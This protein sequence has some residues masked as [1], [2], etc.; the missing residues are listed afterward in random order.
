MLSSKGIKFQKAQRASIGCF[1][2]FP[3]SEG[4]ISL[5]NKNNIQI[6]PN[7]LSN[8]FDR[9]LANKAFRS[10]IDLLMK[11]C[12]SNSG[13]NLIIYVIELNIRSETFS[14]FHLIGTNRMS[15]DKN[16]G[17]V[18]E[19]LKYLESTISMY[20]TPQ[21]FQ[22]SFQHINICLLWLL[23]DFLFKSGFLSD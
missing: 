8:K 13:N 21:Y 23:E 6:D 18:D 2:V 20:V 3:K 5:D 10:G 16:S 9:A 19:V 17:V 15:N 12:F 14:G 7:Y 4:S 22:I 11:A 1:Q